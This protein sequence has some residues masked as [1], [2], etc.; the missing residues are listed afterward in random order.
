MTTA[1]TA[2]IDCV[3]PELSAVEQRFHDE[4][5]SD[6]DGVN[7]LVRWHNAV[8]KARQADWWD[9]GEN[10]ISFRR[11]PGWVAFNNNTTPKQITV[12]TGLPR[13]S[14]C[15]LVTRTSTGCTSHVSVDSHGRTTVTVP[16]KG[17]IAILR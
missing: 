11:G 6:F 13:G 16:A 9:D 14:Y 2:L 10:V 17:A 3:A 1:M 15:D 4:L 12:D 5:V 7:A 8:G